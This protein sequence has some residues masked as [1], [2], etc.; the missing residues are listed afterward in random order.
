MPLIKSVYETKAVNGGQQHAK[1][2]VY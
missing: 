1:V 2:Q